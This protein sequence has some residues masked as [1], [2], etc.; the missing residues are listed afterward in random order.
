MAGC[1]LLVASFGWGWRA[2]VFSPWCSTEGGLWQATLGALIY[3]AISLP[4]IGFGSDSPD[5]G[6]AVAVCVLLPGAGV[7][8]GVVTWAMSDILSSVAGHECGATGP[9][10][11]AIPETCMVTLG[12]FLG[13]VL[14][15]AAQYVHYGTALLLPA[16]LALIVGGWIAFIKI[17][18]LDTSAFE[19]EKASGEDDDG[20]EWQQ[21]RRG[22]ARG[23]GGEAVELRAG[24]AS[25]IATPPAP[26]A[27]AAAA[28]G[29]V[30]TL[31]GSGL[32]PWGGPGYSLED[33]CSSLYQ[34]LPY[35]DV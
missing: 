17:P 22:I 35:M 4:V 11:A 1:G 15:L 7:S 3:L 26:F 24:V 20:D 32:T 2:K 12:T 14:G 29:F 6:M 9:V 13:L 23:P 28:G 31:P 21:Q 8:C 5:T 33:Y 27:A 25:H 16:L 10:S 19:F 34:L 30:S 18:H